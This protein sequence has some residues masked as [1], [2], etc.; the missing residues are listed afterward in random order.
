MSAPEGP[1]SD[2]DGLIMLY[3]SREPADSSDGNG[4][5]FW[6]F[7]TGGQGSFRLKDAQMPLGTGG[8]L[9]NSDEDGT[10]Q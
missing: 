1:K 4:R 3:F 10:N 5:P 8:I 9:S 2:R 7:K 6:M